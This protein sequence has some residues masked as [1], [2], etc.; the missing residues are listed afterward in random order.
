MINNENRHGYV[1]RGE[2]NMESASGVGR[3]DNVD[4]DVISVM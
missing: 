4:S 2:E 1:S 3:H